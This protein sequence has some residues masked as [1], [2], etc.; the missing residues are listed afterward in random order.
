MLLND[1]FC[2]FVIVIVNSWCKDTN[3]LCVIQIF[4]QEFFL[5]RHIF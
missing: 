4:S 3:N 2:I 1:I 5:L